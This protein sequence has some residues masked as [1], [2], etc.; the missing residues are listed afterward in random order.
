[1]SLACMIASHLEP[2][3]FEVMYG[4]TLHTLVMAILIDRWMG[5]TQDLLHHVGCL[6]VWIP[7]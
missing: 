6:Q 3:A 7:L 4:G 1:M 2:C 5:T